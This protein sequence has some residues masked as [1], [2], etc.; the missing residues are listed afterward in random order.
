MR[1]KGTEVEVKVNTG[2]EFT[3]RSSG[4]TVWTR[5]PMLPDLAL[6]ALT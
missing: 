3:I 6:T 1:G 4:L 5:R 2:T